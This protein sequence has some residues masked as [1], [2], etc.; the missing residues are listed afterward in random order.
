MLKKIEENKN[1]IFLIL[2]FA[3]LFFIS[4]MFFY[5]SYKQELVQKSYTTYDINRKY[6]NSYLDKNLI[7]RGENA[8]ESIKNNT[9]LDIFK[10]IELKYEK[11][12][13]NKSILIDSLEQFNDKSWNIAEIK[14]DVALGRI[15]EIK[16]SNL[17]RFVP[18]LQFEKEDDVNI[19]LQLYK[20]SKIK[21]F[22]ARLKF[23]NINYIDTK[24]NS[25]IFP[26]FI[27]Q[28]ITVDK[29]Q[30][31]YEVKVDD[32]KYATVKYELNTSIIK[33]QLEV[34]ILKLIVFTSIMLIPLTFTIG[35]YHNYILRKFVKKPVS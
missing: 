32:Y 26:D 13:F 23:A 35:S 22:I 15:E 28:L 24:K 8:L 31:S 12:I 9:K 20:N 6:I 34:F 21:N 3:F 5:D 11:L 25:R 29:L 16:N 10:K 2:V 1:Y 7:N 18:S 27:N 17:Y 30:N 14:V 33:K 19:R 4:S